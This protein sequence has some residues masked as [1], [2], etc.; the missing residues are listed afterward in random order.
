MPNVATPDLFAVASRVRARLDAH[1]D[2]FDI[3]WRPSKPVSETA[4]AAVE[5][6]LGMT[7]PAPLRAF[8]TQSAGGLLFAWEMRRGL[9]IE[10]RGSWLRSPSYLST[11]LAVRLRLGG[12]LPQTAMP[13]VQ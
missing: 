12:T 5:K 4:L 9:A 3:T 2:A 7:L 8:Y 13:P 1:R 6:R 10:A 11:E